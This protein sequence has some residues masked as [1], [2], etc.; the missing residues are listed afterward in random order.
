MPGASWLLYV[1]K[2]TPA[3]LNGSAAHARRIW[4]GRVAMRGLSNQ[5]DALAE[6]RFRQREARHEPSG[7]L[8][9]K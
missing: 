1:V 4:P 5:D 6:S 2:N 9:M 3:D 7:E 8:T